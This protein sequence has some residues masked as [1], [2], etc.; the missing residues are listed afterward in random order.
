[1]VQSAPAESSSEPAKKPSPDRL[2]WSEFDDIHKLALKPVQAL[3]NLVGSKETHPIL[4]E[5]I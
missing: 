3:V 1:M 5:I 4:S 2:V